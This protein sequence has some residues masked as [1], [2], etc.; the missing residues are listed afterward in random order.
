M[1]IKVLLRAIYSG[2][3]AWGRTRNSRFKVYCDA[4]S[5][6]AYLFER[7]LY[8]PSSPKT[9]GQG[10]HLDIRWVEAG[11]R[12]PSHAVTAQRLPRSTSNWS[13]EKDSNPHQ[14]GRNPNTVHPAGAL[15]WR[16]T[17]VTIPA[18][19]VWSPF[20]A[21]HREPCLGGLSRSRTSLQWLT[22]TRFPAI[23]TKP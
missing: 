13:P 7:F 10:V 12:T 18:S 5:L 20:H 22:A 14:R 8:L 19:R 17:K 1:T 15:N 3:P 4:I 21:L 2:R 11:S 9:I 6:K 16:P 23:A